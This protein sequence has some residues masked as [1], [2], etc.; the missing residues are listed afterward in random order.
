LADLE[1]ALKLGMG[2][3]NP[4]FDTARQ[5]GLKKII[6]TLEELRKKYGDFY[7]ANNY[8]PSLLD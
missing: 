4:L 8:L 2:L 1:T 6:T 7:K 5:F 3:R